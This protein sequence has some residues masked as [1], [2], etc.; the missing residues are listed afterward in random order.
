[1]TIIIEKDKIIS[2]QNGFTKPGIGNKTVDLKTKNV[3]P[4][5]MDMHVHL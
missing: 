2:V 3:T 5:W 4:G 1:M